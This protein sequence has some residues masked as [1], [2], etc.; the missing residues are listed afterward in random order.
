MRKV[1]MHEAKTSLSKLVEALES[2]TENEITIARNGTP[3]ARLTRI[4]QPTQVQRRI[5]IARGAFTL[6]ADNAEFDREIAAL[7]AAEQ[8][9]NK[10]DDS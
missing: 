5:G 9:I 7:F 3:V 8:D 4:D 1:N 6:P 2:G 10:G